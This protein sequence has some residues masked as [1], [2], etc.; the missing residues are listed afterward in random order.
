MFM[1][2]DALVESVPM[3]KLPHRMVF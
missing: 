1:D 3:V 2:I